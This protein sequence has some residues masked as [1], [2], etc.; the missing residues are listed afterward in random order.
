MQIQPTFCGTSLHYCGVQPLLDGV[1][2]YLPSPLDVP[3]VEGMQ[4][5]SRQEG[6]R[7]ARPASRRTDEPF[8]GLVFKIS[9][10][11]HADLCFVR[12]YS[13]VLKSGSRLL[14]PRTGKKETDQPALAYPG[15]RRARRSRPTRSRPATSSAWS[16]RRRSSPATRLRPEAPDPAG[17]HRLSRDGHLD[18]RRAGNQRRPQEARRGPARCSPSR[19]RRSRPRSA[20]RPA[21]RSSAAWANCTWRSSANRLQRDF[22]L[23]VES[24]SRASRTARRSRQ[25]RRRKGEFHRTQGT[26]AVRPRSGV[27]IEPFD[28]EEAVAVASDLQAGRLPAGADAAHADQAVLESAQSGGIVRLP[29]D[30]REVHGRAGR[31]PRGETTEEAP[32]RRVG[33]AVQNALNKADVALLSRS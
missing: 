32:P 5:Q 8:A 14:N 9:A 26:T 4:S 20:K 16:A 23:N 15:R 22:N 31:L 27:R 17:E 25:R 33:Q 11:K 19:T 7:R 13:G 12:V 10:D 3:P 21:R 6:N 24:T 1:N 2:R 28:G 18:G 29:A 30:A